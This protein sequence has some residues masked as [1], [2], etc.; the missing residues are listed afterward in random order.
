MTIPLAPGSSEGVRALP[1]DAFAA[2]QEAAVGVRLLQAL[3][4]AGKLMQAIGSGIR[5][6]DVA[7][8][9]VPVRPVPE[10][11]IPDMGVLPYC[12]SL[13]RDA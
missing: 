4:D 9:C 10:I 8:V 11:S 12:K 6:C 5:G 1:A 13:E 2:L 7:L 3:T